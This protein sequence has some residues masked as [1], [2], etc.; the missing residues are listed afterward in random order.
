MRK[1][2]FKL[3]SVIG[4]PLSLLYMAVRKSLTRYCIP[5][6]VIRSKDSPIPKEKL[7]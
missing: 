6:D 2:A 4:S 5:R 3:C 1:R 7:R